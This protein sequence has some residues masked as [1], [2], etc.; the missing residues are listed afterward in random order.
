MSYPEQE[1][2]HKMRLLRIDTQVFCELEG[3]A[4]LTKGDFGL[5]AAS[6]PEEE[7]AHPHIGLSLEWCRGSPQRGFAR[8]VPEVVDWRQLRQAADIPGNP[9]EQLRLFHEAMMHQM[10]Q[11]MCANIV[12]PQENRLVRSSLGVAQV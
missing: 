12:G 8:F 4:K 5:L 9:E 11:E 1:W 6:V 3:T 2:P 7:R 10:L